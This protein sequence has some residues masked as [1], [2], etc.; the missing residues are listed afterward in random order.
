MAT[1]HLICGLPGAG[2]TTLARHLEAETH[3]LRLCPDEWIEE[4]VT[5]AADRAELDRLRAPVEKLQWTMAQQLLSLGVSV[6]LE[7]G[8]W[9]RD[10]RTVCC[11]TAKQLDAQVVLHFLNIPKEELW[12]RIQ[13][14]NAGLPDGGFRISEHELDK[15]CTWFTPPGETELGLY[16]DFQVYGVAEQVR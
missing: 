6:I 7:N 13:M 1:L 2:K 14:R 4:L 12:R 16:D 10:E 15:W 9:S 8:F 11:G 5:N 3:A